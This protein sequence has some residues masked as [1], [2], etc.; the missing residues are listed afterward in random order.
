MNKAVDEYTGNDLN[1]AI[2]HAQKMAMATIECTYHNTKDE[3]CLTCDEMH[4]VKKALQAIEICHALKT[5][6]RL[7]P[8]KQCLFCMTKGDHLTAFFYI[9]ILAQQK[10]MSLQINY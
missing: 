7:A 8:L 10:Y 4:K 9:F 6:I 1:V 2:D 5:N 3:D